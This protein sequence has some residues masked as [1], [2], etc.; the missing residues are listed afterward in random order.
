MMDAK[1][2]DNTRI[3]NANLG[4]NNDNMKFEEEFGF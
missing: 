1:V 2:L 4:E 3:V